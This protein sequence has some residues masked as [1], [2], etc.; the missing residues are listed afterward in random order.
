MNTINIFGWKIEFDAL[1]WI[2]SLIIVGIPMLFLISKW[3]RIYIKK[4]MSAQQAMIISK[5]IMYFGLVIILLSILQKLNFPLATLYG[6]AGIIGIALAFASQTSVSNII[7]GL[8]LI[9]ERPFEV[10]DIIKIGNTT[11]V[12]LSVD[13][14]SIK[15]RTFDNK[16]VRIP[17]ETIVKSELTNVTK[18]P[19][20]RV[21]MNVGVAYKEDIG[22]VREILLDVAKKNPL[23]LNDPEPIVV[24]T[25]FGN[26]SLDFLFG[27]WAVKSDW[28]KLKNSIAEDVKKRFDEKGIEIPFPHLSLYSGSKT[29][30][31]PISIVGKNE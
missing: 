15:L 7:S 9:A 21:E 10:D 2:V 23:C 19:I 20:R 6:S 28:L 22:S 31:I 17:N 25:G 26:S 5:F 13:V 24:F 3:V 11:G 14:L 4:K 18:F 16:F 30:P 8:F 1:F 12:V 27:V 29:E